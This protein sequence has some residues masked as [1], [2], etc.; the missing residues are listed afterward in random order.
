MARRIVLEVGSSEQD[1]VIVNGDLDLS[2]AEIVFQLLSGV[3]DSFVQQI[4]LSDFIEVEDNGNTAP[5]DLG[6]FS[7]TQFN[8]QDA[9]GQSTR[10]ALTSSGGVN[11]VPEPFSAALMLFGV[12]ALLRKN[13]Q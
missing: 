10:L 3:D 8:V 4:Q 2:Q 13:R 9:S 11:Q 12:G 5:L 6:A 7:T 1:K